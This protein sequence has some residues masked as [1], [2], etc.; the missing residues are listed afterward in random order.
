MGNI[1]LNSPHDHHLTTDLSFDDVSIQCNTV[2]KNLNVDHEGI[3]LIHFNYTNILSTKCHID[4]PLMLIQKQ[5]D[6]LE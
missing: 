1:I 4:Y 6:I 2:V 5:G 3:D